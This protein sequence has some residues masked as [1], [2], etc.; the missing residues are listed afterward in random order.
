MPHKVQ[1]VIYTDEYWTNVYHTKN[2]EVYEVEVI[3]VDVSQFEDRIP[4]KYDLEDIKSDLDKIIIPEAREVINRWY[5]ENKEWSD[6]LEESIKK[7]AEK[8]K[9]E[10]LDADRAVLERYGVADKVDWND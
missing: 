3:K 7:E 4:D 1:V 10:K 2:D 6:E 9:Q 5:T 8:K